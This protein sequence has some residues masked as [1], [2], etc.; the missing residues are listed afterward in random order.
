[1]AVT[2]TW[3][4][5]QGINTVFRQPADTTASYW[6]ASTYL[7]LET[8]SIMCHPS[9]VLPRQPKD[10]PLS[11]LF[12]VPGCPALTA[13]RS[14]AAIN[15]ALKIIPVNSVVAVLST[16]TS[17]FPTDMVSRPIPASS[18]PGVEFFPGDGGGFGG[19]WT[20][21]DIFVAYERLH[22][23]AS[24]CTSEVAT[25]YGHA[26]FGPPQNFAGPF[27]RGDDSTHGGGSGGTGGL[28]E[29]YNDVSDRARS[30]NKL[31]RILVTAS[32]PGVMA[33]QR[34]QPDVTVP[35]DKAD[36]KAVSSAM[37]EDEKAGG[38]QR[39]AEDGAAT[40][41]PTKTRPG[42]PAAASPLSVLPTPTPTP[43]MTVR[44]S[45]AAPFPLL[46]FDVETF[47]ALGEL[48]EGFAFQGG[49]AEWIS[50]ATSWSSEGSDADMDCPSFLNQR[51]GQGRQSNGKTDDK[52]Y[53][54]RG[55]AV[56]NAVRHVH[57]REWGRR[58]V[59]SWSTVYNEDGKH[60]RTDAASDANSDT[61]AA[62]ENIASEDSTG[63]P[64]ISGAS[65]ASVVGGQSGMCEDWAG[66]QKLLRVCDQP[67]SGQPSESAKLPE[68]ETKIDQWGSLPPG[69][70]LEQLVQADADLFFLRLALSKSSTG[71]ETV[72]LA[73]NRALMANST[74]EQ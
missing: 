12:H 57:D 16:S 11:R 66:N 17:L 68:R 43:K 48:D 27:G 24:A 50:R 74:I 3:E 6:R 32:P 42:A 2:H 7:N 52:S 51:Q 56:K 61:R 25:G 72:E 33:G 41:Q 60:F 8:E 5:E 39:N 59:R 65:D 20:A 46:V 21:G 73:H 9:L 62:A 19:S 55:F 14:S 49:I 10:W 63:A 70:F 28:Y 38:D 54:R 30:S 18:Q 23:S 13:E 15:R 35:R 69:R 36:T 22:S 40:G 47:V 29:E 4:G 71:E 26:S 44:L 1:M 34:H 31:L 45:D 37:A 67:R 58:F 64:P 53:S